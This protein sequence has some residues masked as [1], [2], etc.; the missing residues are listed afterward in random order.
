MVEVLASSLGDVHYPAQVEQ[1]DR[2]IGSPRE[3]LWGGSCPDAATV[4]PLSRQCRWTATWNF[5]S[6]PQSVLPFSGGGKRRARVVWDQG[7]DSARQSG[8]EGPQVE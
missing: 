2:G 6:L 5:A 3:R 7:G 4:T 8:L 1:I